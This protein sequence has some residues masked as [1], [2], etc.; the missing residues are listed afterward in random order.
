MVFGLRGARAASLN[1]DELG[2][3]LRD[4]ILR[5]EG[6][7]AAF[8]APDPPGDIFTRGHLALSGLPRAG[9]RQEH[10]VSA[11][12]RRDRRPHRHLHRRSGEAVEAIVCATGY[13]IDIP[14]L[15]DDGWAVLGPDLALDQR[16]SIPISPASASSASSSPRAPTSRCSSCRR[17]GSSGLVR[18]RPPPDEAACAARS[19][20]RR[21]RSTRTTRSRRRSPKSRRGARPA[22]PARAHRALLF[23]PL[24]PPRYR[25]EG[26]GA[27]A[28]GR[29]AV[30]AHSS[31]RHP[32]P[33]STP[34]TSRSSAGSGWLHAADILTHS[35]EVLRNG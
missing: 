35:T 22:R 20:S 1:R 14:Y 27:S 5:V 30:H 16:R 21:Q 2:R 32:R 11:R 4:R 7:P 31:P 28:R 6:S 19:P 26:P 18:R 9:R 24:L 15:D 25:L 10:R 34:T 13:D 17:A 33:P 23:G 12:D 29:G 3:R 8:G